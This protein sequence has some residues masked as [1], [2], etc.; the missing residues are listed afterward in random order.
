MSAT[1]G[2]I[3]NFAVWLGKQVWNAV[4]TGYLGA[5]RD[6]L[7]GV[8]P[9]LPPDAVE[10]LKEVRRRV[11]PYKSPAPG[12]LL[13]LLAEQYLS[14]EIAESMQADP[15]LSTWQ[16]LVQHLRGR[17]A[18]TPALSEDD[19]RDQIWQALLLDIPEHERVHI[20]KSRFFELLRAKEKELLGKAR[21]FTKSRS[22][23]NGW[24]AEKQP[25]LKLKSGR[26]KESVNKS[27]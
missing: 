23:L 19:R 6:Y 20:R 18:I 16:D 7:G 2:R 15:P 10:A 21:L 11:K 3:P 25:P 5:G 4:E 8:Y 13:P 22:T 12:Q 26:P 27:T 9:D 14:A 1:S 24:W 17:P